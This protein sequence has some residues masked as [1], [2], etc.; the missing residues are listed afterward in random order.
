METAGYYLPFEPSM[1]LDSY[2]P[3]LRMEDMRAKR[4]ETLA[5]L[6]ELLQGRRHLPSVDDVVW[7]GPITE[8]VDGQ[9]HRSGT[10]K[11]TFRDDVA[12]LYEPR[13]RAM[14]LNVHI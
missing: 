7:T 12:A 1:W 9:A 2:P 5:L 13:K 6:S 8:G 4:P 10:L 14:I 11:I 3:E